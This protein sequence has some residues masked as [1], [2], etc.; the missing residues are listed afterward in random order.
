MHKLFYKIFIEHPISVGE[1]YS[2][3]F[4]YALGLS[5]IFLMLVATSLVHA[6]VPC[7][8]KDTASNWAGMLDARLQNRRD[9]V[10]C[11]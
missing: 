7:L 6:F 3:H 4:K 2:Q 10:D 1:T 11:T 8:F 9:N 5:F